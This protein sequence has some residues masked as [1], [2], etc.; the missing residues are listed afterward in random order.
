MLQLAEE[1]I[2]IPQLVIERDLHRLSGRQ[3]VVLTYAIYMKHFIGDDLD[4]GQ[5]I[6]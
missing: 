3:L 4:H 1:V 5:F 2:G 6:H